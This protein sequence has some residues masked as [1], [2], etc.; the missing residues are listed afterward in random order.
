MTESVVVGGGRGGGGWAA[1]TPKTRREPSEKFHA[2]GRG[3]GTVPPSATAVRR[4]R[5]ARGGVG[6]DRAS[7]GARPLVEIHHPPGITLC[8][9]GWWPHHTHHTRYAHLQQQHQ[10]GSTPDIGTQQ[11][12]PQGH[13]LQ[14]YKYCMLIVSCVLVHRVIYIGIWDKSRGH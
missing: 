1:G 4:R 10:V 7:D 6:A 13:Q 2:L 8:P 5:R 14:V 9:G 3:R 12:Q 11:R